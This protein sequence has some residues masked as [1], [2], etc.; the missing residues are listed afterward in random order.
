M[1]NYVSIFRRRTKPTC[2]ICSDFWTACG[3]HKYSNLDVLPCKATRLTQ[4]GTSRVACK[5][6]LDHLSTTSAM[7]GNYHIARSAYLVVCMSLLAGVVI[8]R[9]TERAIN[10][11]SAEHGREATSSVC[12]DDSS[13]TVLFHMFY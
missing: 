11:P 4:R 12:I 10:S 6:A 3:L 13:V 1:H 8:V 2:T 5:D 7:S 9:L